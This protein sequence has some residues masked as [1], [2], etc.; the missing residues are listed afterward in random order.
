MFGYKLIKKSE[1][2]SLE[3][4]HVRLNWISSSK[5]WFSGFQSTMQLINDLV[6]SCK[7][8]DQIRREYAERENKNEWGGPKK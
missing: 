4:A 5:Y 3:R 1:Y 7:T 6:H 2:E 8:I